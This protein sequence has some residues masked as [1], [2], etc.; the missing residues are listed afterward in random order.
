MFIDNELTLPDVPRYSDSNGNVIYSQRDVNNFSNDELEKITNPRKRILHEYELKD[1]LKVDN[2][3]YIRAYLTTV[4]NN[5]QKY[6]RPQLNA[7]VKSGE[8][9]YVQSYRRSNG[10][11]VEGYYRRYPDSK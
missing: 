11:V 6:T 1:L 3:D 5:P 8:L 10:T 4:Y 7:M 2:T 9:I